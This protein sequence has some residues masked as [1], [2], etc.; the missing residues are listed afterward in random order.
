MVLPGSTWEQAVWSVVILMPSKIVKRLL[1]TGAGTNSLSEYYEEPPERGSRASSDLL[2]H[3]MVL[4]GME[5]W[6]IRMGPEAVYRKIN[7][8]IKK[9]D[10][11]PGDAM[12]YAKKNWEIFTK[13]HRAGEVGDNGESLGG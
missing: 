2:W 12:Q 3:A 7:D 10:L 9:Y 4:L 5:N 11:R 8:L 1:E 13:L 6:N